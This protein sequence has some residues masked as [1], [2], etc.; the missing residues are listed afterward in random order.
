MM[1]CLR[2]MQKFLCTMGNVV[3]KAS[4]AYA[5]VGPLSQ[6]VIITVGDHYLLSS[7]FFF[8][9]YLLLLIAYIHLFVHMFYYCHS[10]SVLIH[11]F[12]PFQ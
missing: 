2:R 11:S 8:S 6:W 5:H 1:L 4:H 10:F 9:N 12:S 3:A 7:L